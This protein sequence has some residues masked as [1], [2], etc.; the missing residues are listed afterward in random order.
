V[1]LYFIPLY[2]LRA[3][4]LNEEAMSDLHL[5]CLSQVEFEMPSYI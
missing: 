4:H 1:R 3:K 5:G 2:V